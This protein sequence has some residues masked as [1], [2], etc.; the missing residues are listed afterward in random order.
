M[1]FKDRTVRAVGAATL[2]AIPAFY[3]SWYFSSLYTSG[4]QLL[5]R[6][7]YK[8]LKTSAL[9]EILF[10][11]AMITGSVEPAYGLIAWFGAQI[12]QKEVWFSFANVA[13]LLATGALMRKLRASWILAPLIF[14]NFYLY[15]FMFTTERL[16]FAMICLAI[17]AVSGKR[18]RYLL[19]LVS[20]LFHFQ[21]V[22]FFSDFL[23]GHAVSLFQRLLR[24]RAHMQEVYLML[25]SGLFFLFLLTIFSERLISKLLIYSSFSVEGT[26]K[27]LAFGVI[28]VAFS[29]K[30][31]SMALT[32]VI[33]AFVAFVV[34]GERVNF[35]AFI[36][37][38]FPTFGWRR[39]LNP[40]TVTILSY[41]SVKGIGHLNDIMI[42]GNGF[43][44]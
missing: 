19:A 20:P 5:Y 4:D 25:F 21:A 10:H 32:F 38:V 8:E 16:K 28:G 37:A 17:A 3:F 23:S 36:F 39:G 26:L 33:I 31:A 29:K 24:L 13:L 41:Y 44:N 1:R 9:Q 43:P 34:G 6:S 30:R 35:I 14:T 12:M 18:W 15:V 22:L 2:L 42:Y 40:V 7:L 11:Q 27:V